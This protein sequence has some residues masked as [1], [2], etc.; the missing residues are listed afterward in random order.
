MRADLVGRAMRLIAD[1][2]VDREGVGGLSRRLGYSERH[3]NRLLTDELGAGPLAVARAQ[4]AQTART[5]IETTSMP[6]TEIAFAAGFTSVRQFNDTVREVFASSPTQLRADR[7]RRDRGSAA[8]D[9]PP[10]AVALRLAVRQPFAAD[11][12]FAFLGHRAVPHVETWDGTTFSL[13]LRLPGGP[14]IASLRSVDQGVVCTLR[15]TSLSDLQAAVQRCRRLLDLDADPVAIDAHLS[16][17]ALLAPLVAAAP[18]LR[19]AGTVDGTE[20]LV[21]GVLGQ[22]VSVAGAR[23]V[24]G[25]LALAVGEV[26]E[27]AGGDTGLPTRLFPSAAALA[28][29]D[30]EMLPMPAARRRAL[31]E[32]C[33]AVAAGA[34]DLAPGADRR[35]LFDA[36]VRLPGIGPWTAQYVAM[37]GLGDPDVFMP[38]DLGVRHALERLGCDGSPG[39]AAALADRWSPWR[40]YALHHLWRT[41]TV[42]VSASS[43]SRT[44][45]A[46]RMTRRGTRP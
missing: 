24:A 9:A 27:L 5:L 35:E 30:P 20:M 44:P 41:L 7:R 36:L 25:R 26:V 19:A 13:G 23:T 43:A 39:A 14:G 33:A 12:L 1:G 8:S 2:V 11:E 28:E 10:G 38:T 45:V 22:Q 31:R 3:L 32:A 29:I 15:L 4:R 6:M 42:P 17:D 16:G 40:S 46:S 21:R 37:R 34:V 18:G